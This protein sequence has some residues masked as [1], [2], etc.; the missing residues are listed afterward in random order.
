MLD[1][2]RI[3]TAQAEAGRNEPRQVEE[4]SH[5]NERATDTF[6]SMQRDATR[7]RDKAELSGCAAS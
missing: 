5:A 4:R 1:I 7:S 2:M 3:A 6:V